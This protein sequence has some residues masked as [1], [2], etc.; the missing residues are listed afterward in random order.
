MPDNVLKLVARI[1]LAV[2]FIVTGLGKLIDP[3]GVAGMLGSLHL[4]GAAAL[5]SVLLVLA[6]IGALSGMVRLIQRAT[7]DIAISTIVAAL[8]SVTIVSLH[9][10]EHQ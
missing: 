10:P 8:I 9:R 7:G 6:L 5:R 4:P 2:L 1:P 3:S